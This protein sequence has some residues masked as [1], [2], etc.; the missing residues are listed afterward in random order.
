MSDIP[1]SLFRQLHGRAPTESDRRRLV[2]VRGALGLSEHD[3]LWPVL[4][5][6]DHYSQVSRHA[7]SVVVKALEDFE[8]RLRRAGE[9]IPAAVAQSVSGAAG[10]SG[11]MP[12][13][14]LLG[15]ALAGILVGGLVGG[16]AGNALA[17][18]RAAESGLCATA[19]ERL[20]DG[21]VACFVRQ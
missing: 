11:R 1:E 20:S 4:M 3:E 19:P 2:A 14:I 21:R 18:N 9:D 16:M 17:W 8:D 13:Q 7:E 15:V 6:L 10:N 5:A 12:R